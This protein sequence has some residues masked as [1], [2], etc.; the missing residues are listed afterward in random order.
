MTAQQLPTPFFIVYE[1]RLR[2]NLELISDVAR[3]SGAEI[4]MAFKAN[5]LWRTFPIIKEYCR[6]CTA[7]S[8]NELLLGAENLGGEI[9][10]YTPAY[11]DSNIDTFIAHST[12]IT[13]NSLG[14]LK[15]YGE[16]A[17]SAGVS[18]GL[19]V[20]PR[21]SVIETDLYNPAL[22]GSRFGVGK[23]D[24][25]DGLPEGV[26]GL[27][28]HALCES[29]PED[30]E[31]VLETFERDFGHLLPELK[32][33]NMGGG[34]LMTRKDYDTDRLVDIIRAFRSRYPGLKV[35]LEPGSAFTWQT[36]DLVSS[37]VDVV[38]DRGIPTAILDV[39]FACHM[40]DTLEMPY[41]PAVAESCEPADGLAPWRLGGNSCLSGDFKGDYYFARP[42]EPGD[43]I[44]LK[45]MNHYTTVKTTMFNGVHHPDMVLERADGTCEYLRR[46]GYEDYKNRMS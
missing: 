41:L 4:I 38:V 42:L 30:L 18:V 15:R 36:G 1:N 6:N 33:V 21:C 32:W 40:P 11:T 5:A 29:G 25:V 26:D 20:N 31:K 12:H 2:A 13:F 28:F 8:V 10:S 23:E 24:L 39:S 17:R 3:R 16:R 43:R 9:H 37:V 7:S 22:P 19:R 14:Q 35:I 44:T 46:F 27:H 34:H 45:D